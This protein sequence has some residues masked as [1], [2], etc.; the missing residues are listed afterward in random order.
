[1]P[2]SRRAAG[3]PFRP[4]SAL[5]GEDTGG[6]RSETTILV[7][8][9]DAQEHRLPADSDSRQTVRTTT[10]DVRISSD[11]RGTIRTLET[12]VRTLGEQLEVANTS[13]VAERSPTLRRK[14]QRQIRYRL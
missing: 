1:M 8:L 4:P 6:A 10:D 9:D 14:G 12:A 3:Y 11:V 7:P 5:S 13:L 2:K